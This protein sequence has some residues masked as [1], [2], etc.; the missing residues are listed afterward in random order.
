MRS[1]SGDAPALSSVA[2]SAT[3]LVVGAAGK[4]FIFKKDGSGDI[5]TTAT[6]SITAYT[7]ESG[8]GGSRVALSDTHL[9]VGCGKPI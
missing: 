8:F 4:A 3:H 6:A 7:G 1:T 5:P 9:M 2:L